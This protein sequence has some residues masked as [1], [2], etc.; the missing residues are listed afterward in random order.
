MAKFTALQNIFAQIL[1]DLELKS[2]EI[3]TIMTHLQDDNQME[4]LVDFIEKNPQANVS[5]LIEQAVKIS[6]V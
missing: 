5:E 1:V 4:K 2:E 3:A 6:K